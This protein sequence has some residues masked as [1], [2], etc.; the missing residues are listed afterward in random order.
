METLNVNKS[1]NQSEKTIRAGFWHR[2]RTVFYST[3][4]TGAS[5]NLMP[6]GITHSQESGV[7]IY[8]ADFSRRF[9]EHVWGIYSYQ[10]WRI[11]LYG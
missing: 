3:P 8:G 11:I 7:K 4:E 6:D 5:K 2:N 9:V 10:W 1:V